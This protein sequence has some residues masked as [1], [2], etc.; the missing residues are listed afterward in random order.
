MEYAKIEIS[1]RFIRAL[2]NVESEAWSEFYRAA[3]PDIAKRFGIKQYR[4]AFGTV[5]VASGLDV[6]ALNRVLG[7]GL[8]KPFASR[9]LEKIIG[10]YRESGTKKFFFQIPPAA[11]PENI[12]GILRQ[13]GLE[14]YNNWVKLYRE[15]GRID[16]PETGLRVEKID[17]GKGGIFG[18]I[19][20]QSFGWPDGGSKWVAGLTGC[21][22]WN[23]YMAFND[24]TPIATGAFFVDGDFA[25]IDFAA[26]LEKYRG[27]GAQKALLKRRMDDIVQAGAKYVVVETAQQTAE[28]DAPSYRNMVRYGFREAYIR[29]NYIFILNN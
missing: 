9:M 25:W 7:P 10:L 22:R 29:P 2:E 15:A 26:T 28:K 17:S 4:E 8:D 12:P 11:R 3:P 13:Y 6:L 14:H 18:D 23:H 21:P 24:D 19:V 27:R 16:I 1:N 5:A 20:A